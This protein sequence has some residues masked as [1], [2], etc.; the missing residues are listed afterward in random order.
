[1][2][3]ALLLGQAEP[4]VVMS[5]SGGGSSA[6]PPLVEMVALLKRE[7]GVKGTNLPDTIDAA[8]RALGLE[9][10]VRSD[11]PLIEKAMRCWR[12]LFVKEEL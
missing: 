5:A 8:I 9:G 4:A 3:V 2:R 6:P 1:M 10:Q 12:L 11:M 7:L